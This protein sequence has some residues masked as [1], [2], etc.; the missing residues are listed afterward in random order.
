MHKVGITITASLVILV[1]FIFLLHFNRK[2]LNG[3]NTYS[4][5]SYGGLGGR[6]GGIVDGGGEDPN[7]VGGY[8]GPGVVDQDPNAEWI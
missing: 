5:F 3:E 8:A 7:Q 6:E 4:A 2:K 1:V